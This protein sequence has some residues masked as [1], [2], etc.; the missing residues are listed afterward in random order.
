MGCNHGE[1]KQ[2]LEQLQQ[3]FS[4]V[5][6]SQALPFLMVL[7][8]MPNKSHQSY[9]QNVHLIALGEKKRK[10]KHKSTLHRLEYYLH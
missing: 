8:F 10:C 1:D 9:E 2:D 7:W 4:G 3:L 6:P 5:F